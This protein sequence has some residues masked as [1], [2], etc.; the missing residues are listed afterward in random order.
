M[1]E[2]KKAP[3][4]IALDRIV[5]I[6]Q[7]AAESDKASVAELVRRAT[8]SKRDAQVLSITPVMAAI[9]FID[10]NK[11]NREWN[12]NS[13]LGYLRQI[14]AGEWEYTCQGIGFLVGGNVGDGQHRLAAIALSGRT[15]EVLVAFGMTEAAIVTLDTGRRRQP[16][17]YL[18]IA[19][20][21]D[22]PAMYKRQQ[23]MVK[24]AFGYLA[25]NPDEERARPFRLRTNRD[26]VRAVESNRASL[27][28]ALDIADQSVR[29]R[30]KPPF[31]DQEAAAFAL[32]CLLSDWPVD[33]ILETLDKFQSGEDREGGDSPLFIAAG[34]VAKDA[35]KR[36]KSSV[37]ARFSAAMKG[38]ILHE[39]RTK[40]VRPT[41]IREAMKT[42]AW[43]NPQFP[44][45]EQPELP[46]TAAE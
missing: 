17:D 24:R 30:V 2:V 3:D 8:S 7:S 29:G 31:T 6:Y 41:V 11:Q 22:D 37:T 35:A 28:Q 34:I 1:A 25:K 10:Y 23:L 21:N 39:K 20:P 36:E 26:V 33:H 46:V 40:A 4:Q 12:Y 27:H 9:L 32:L 43:V 19:N 16:A 13:T 15:I 44:V 14:E 42:K 18:H 5:E 38:F 45:E